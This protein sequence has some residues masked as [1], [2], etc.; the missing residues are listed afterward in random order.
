MLLLVQG[1]F[2]QDAALYK[3]REILSYKKAVDYFPLKAQ[4]WMVHF[5]R[6]GF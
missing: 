6:Q 4:A 2:V 3:W 5:R 1:A